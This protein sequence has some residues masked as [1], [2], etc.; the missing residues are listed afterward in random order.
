LV[1]LI[2][3]GIG[4]TANDGRKQSALPAHADKTDESAGGR[5]KELGLGDA[6]STLSPAERQLVG[7]YV[8]GVGLPTY[9]T[10]RLSDFG[11]YSESIGSCVGHAASDD[12][13]WR[14][15]ED[16]VVL[17]STGNVGASSGEHRRYLTVGDD[18]QMPVLVDS[19]RV[20]AFLLEGPTATNCYQRQ[21]KN[22]SEYWLRLLHGT[23]SRSQQSR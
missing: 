19:E 20:S 13:T 6:K 12:G 22:E 18:D 9:A 11:F 10:L 3:A 15:E 7:T 2:L 14:L 8:L 16:R 17:L 23:E 21:A 4:C 5:R 1:L